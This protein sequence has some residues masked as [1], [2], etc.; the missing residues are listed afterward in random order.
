MF[1][2]FDLHIKHRCTLLCTCWTDFSPRRD[3]FLV[4]MHRFYTHVCNR[5]NNGAAYRCR[6]RQ[7]WCCLGVWTNNIL[8]WESIAT[9]VNRHWHCSWHRWGKSCTRE[10]GHFVGNTTHDGK[11]KMHWS[12]KPRFD[13]WYVQHCTGCIGS[14]WWHGSCSNTCLGGLDEEE[15]EVVQESEKVANFKR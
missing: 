7:W 8:L 11:C 10:P 13:R 15:M 5:E 9:T 1:E 2:P 6:P 14:N 3:K 4:P 12:W